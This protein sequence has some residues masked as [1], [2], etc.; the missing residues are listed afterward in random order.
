MWH[1]REALCSARGIGS[2]SNVPHGGNDT[3]K[4]CVMRRALLGG[5]LLP[6]R[7]L[8][9]ILDGERAVLLD[10]VEHKGPCLRTCAP[11]SKMFQAVRKTATHDSN[12]E[13]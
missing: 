10:D 12:E 7:V 1:P 13:R 4:V 5:S 6:L 9:Q 2:G 3:T 11:C 8:V